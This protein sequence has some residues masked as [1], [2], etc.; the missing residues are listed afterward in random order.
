MGWVW[1]TQANDAPYCPVG[2]IAEGWTTCQ[3]LFHILL[4]ALVTANTSALQVHRAKWTRV[5]G[6]CSI[7]WISRWQRQ[8]N[9]L[10]RVQPGGK[11]AL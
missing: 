8:V 11:H 6:R 1:M 9:I 10:S 2:L 5:T 3:G 4:S 7:I